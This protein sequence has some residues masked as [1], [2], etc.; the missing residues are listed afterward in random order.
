M[1]FVAR[2]MEIEGI[3]L[4]EVSQKE[5]NTVYHLYV[6]LKQDTN[7]PFCETE[8]DSW[9]SGLWLLRGVWGKERLGVWD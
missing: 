4:N 1:P 6:K 8:T 5:T 7:E 2:F 9:T 3:M